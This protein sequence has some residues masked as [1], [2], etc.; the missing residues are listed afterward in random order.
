M[1]PIRPGG[2]GWPQRLARQ[3]PEGSLGERSCSGPEPGISA[4]A[5]S[6]RLPCELFQVDI[7]VGGDHL[8]R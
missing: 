1:A 8:G 6:P 3:H 7:V 5:G 2:S 4:W